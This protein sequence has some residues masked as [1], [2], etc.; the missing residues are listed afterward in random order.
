MR[1]KCVKKQETEGAD[2]LDKR[3]G[4]KMKCHQW[5]DRKRRFQTVSYRY[6]EVSALTGLFSSLNKAV[7]LSEGCV[8]STPQHSRFHNRSLKKIKCWTM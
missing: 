6:A 1:G 5:K 8:C 2:M 7:L 3:S 4:W